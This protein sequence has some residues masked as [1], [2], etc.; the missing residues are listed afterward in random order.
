MAEYYIGEIRVF[1][2]NYEP[3]GWAFCD[4]RTLNIYE[5]EALY[6]LLGTT[7]GGNGVSTFNLPDLRGRLALH[8][9]TGTGLS[10]YTLGQQVGVEDVTLN[11]ATMPSHSHALLASSS[12]S[13]AATPGPTVMPGKSSAGFY[14]PSTA[15]QFKSM[16]MDPTAVGSTGSATAHD[17]NMPTLPLSYIIALNGIFPMQS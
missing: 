1:A 3:Q 10:T 9:G 2:G 7:Y 16:P 5:Y 12:A 13:T 11:S 6:T 4:G 14:T 17:N 15:A 8:C